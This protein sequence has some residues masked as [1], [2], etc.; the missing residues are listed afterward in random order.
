[1]E[2]GIRS[3]L[4]LGHT[5]AHALE[6][7][8]GYGS[9]THGEAVAIGLLFSFHV[10]E[11]VFKQLLPFDQLQ[12]WLQLNQYPVKETTIHT[13]NILEKMKADKKTTH[14]QIK[15]VLLES[16]ENLTVKELSDKTISHYL[17]TF[18]ERMAKE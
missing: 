2:L 15:M 11:G 8:L 9:I 16:P 4:N 12:T 3:H 13:E 1:K 7:D 17:E 5:F 6:A 18:K 10:S 14:Q